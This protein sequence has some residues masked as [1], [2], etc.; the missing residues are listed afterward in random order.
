M[1]LQ[2]PEWAESDNCQRCQ[3]PFFWNFK[4]MYDQKTIGIRQVR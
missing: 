4:S 3:K 2:T 1:F